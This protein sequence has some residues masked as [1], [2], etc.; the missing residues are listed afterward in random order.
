MVAS[1]K[2]RGLQSK[3]L[4]EMTKERA[5]GPGGHQRKIPRCGVVPSSMGVGLLLIQVRLC[6][7]IWHFRGMFHGCM[8]ISLRCQVMHQV[9]FIF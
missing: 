6:L 5:L 4:A 3:N 7:G 8:L 1:Q 9:P 2:P